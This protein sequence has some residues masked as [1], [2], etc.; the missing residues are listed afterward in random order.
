MGISVKIHSVS[1]TNLLFLEQIGIWK[2]LFSWKELNR[3]MGGN[4]GHY[5]KH[6]A[7]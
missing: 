5:F 4:G 3:R 6:I 1:F 2:H 7:H